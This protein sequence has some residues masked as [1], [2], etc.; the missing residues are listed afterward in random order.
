MRLPVALS[1]FGHGFIRLAKLQAFSQWMTGTMENSFIPPV[2]VVILSYVL[3]FIELILGISLMIG[4]KARYSIY[5]GLVLMSVLI[6]GS[7]SIED[8]K[9]IEA[10]LIHAIYLFGLLWYMEKNI[11]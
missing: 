11:E 10:Q 4:F 7:A 8:W 5:A 2:L 3:P 6:F 9:A 1:L